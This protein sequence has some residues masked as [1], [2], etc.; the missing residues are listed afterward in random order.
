MSVSLIDEL[1]ADLRPVRRIAPGRMI[2]GVAVATLAAVAAT[3]LLFG[4]RGDVAALRPDQIVMLR[5]SALL[6]LGFAATV[7][8]VR[9][10]RP[11]IAAPPVGWRWA[12]GFYALFPVSSLLMI[13]RG[14]AVA[15]S[16][17]VTD[18]VKDCLAISLTVALAIGAMLLVWLRRG[19]VVDLGF[20]GWLVGLASGA[21]GVFAYSLHCPNDSI[22]YIAL[23]YSLALLIAAAVGRLATPPLL[24]W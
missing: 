17:A 1:T 8:V 4:L 14:D 2:A 10:A 12:L 13:V 16:Y 6:L 7:A 20:A 5:G 24:R 9:S 11:A 3:G 21:L 18:T 15:E 22:H 23:W 19:A